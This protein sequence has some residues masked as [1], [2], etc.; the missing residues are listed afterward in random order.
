VLWDNGSGAP[1]V[2]S[3]VGFFYEP[4]D[5]NY[6]GDK[7]LEALMN[8]GQA[9]LDPKKREETYR[10]IFNKANEERYSMPITPIPSVMA[11]TKD[12]KVPTT[13]TRKPEGFILNLLEWK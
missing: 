13:G 9:E 2:E 7:E 3:S 4:G 8:K 6:N 11:H 1:D 12:L 10:A 5:R